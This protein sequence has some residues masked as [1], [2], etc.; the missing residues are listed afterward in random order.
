MPGDG[1]TDWQARP[2]VS[3][4]LGGII[5]RTAVDQFA[6]LQFVALHHLFVVRDWPTH[7]LDFRSG[8]SV[9]V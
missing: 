2:T 7:T 8:E 4:A 3:A 9:K 1:R 5:A 6:S